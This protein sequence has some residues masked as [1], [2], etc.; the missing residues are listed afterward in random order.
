[1]Q[2]LQCLKYC[3]LTSTLIGKEMLV[4]SKNLHFKNVYSTLLAVLLP[5]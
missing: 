4:L 5:S 3:L 1:M 2:K